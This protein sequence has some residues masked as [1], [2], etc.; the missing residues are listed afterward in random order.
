MAN[1]SKND[2][3]AKRMRWR[4]RSS[5]EKIPHCEQKSRCKSI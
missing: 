4:A 5:A 2:E 3:L 1:E